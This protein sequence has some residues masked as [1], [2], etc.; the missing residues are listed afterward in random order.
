[1][2]P[3][4]PSPFLDMMPDYGALDAV[5]AALSD[6]LSNLDF[7]SADPEP[8]PGLSDA[9]EIEAILTRLKAA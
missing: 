7:A 9:D 1:M 3:L 5:Q 6:V 8:P 2:T 4:P